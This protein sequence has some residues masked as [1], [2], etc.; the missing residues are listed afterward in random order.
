MLTLAG[1]KKWMDLYGKASEES[2][3]KAAAELFTH[4]AEYYETPFDDPIIGQDAIYRYWTEAARY[5]KDV[6]FSYEIVTVAGNLGIAL[7]QA[8]F[9]NVRSGNHVELDGVFMVE[10]D[11]DQKCS[12]FREWWHRQVIDAGANDT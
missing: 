5:L 1:F 12:R 6:R 3:P 10:F 8:K 7:W 2:D 9:V 4:N 11:Q